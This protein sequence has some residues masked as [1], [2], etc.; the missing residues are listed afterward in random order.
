MAR[1]K[2]NLALFFAPG[3]LRPAVVST[4]MGMVFA[5]GVSGYALGLTWLGSFGPV[6]GWG[7]LTSSTILTSGFWD[8]A[9]KEW[10]GRPLRVMVQGIATLVAAVALLALGQYFH[11]P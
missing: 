7:I 10:S 1:S 6:V 5:L 2:R 8:L 11:R 9:Q 3:S 4:G